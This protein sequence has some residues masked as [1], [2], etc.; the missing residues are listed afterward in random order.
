MIEYYVHKYKDD[1]GDHEVHRSDCEW[2]INIE[3][4]ICLG[5]FNNCHQAVQAAKGHFSNV[6]G[7]K[8]CSKECDTS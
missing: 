2:I 5:S 6:N 3:N 8:H 1:K 7:C 4:F